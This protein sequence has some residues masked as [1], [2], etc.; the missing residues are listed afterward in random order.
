[1]R[2][3]AALAVGI[4][5]LCAAVSYA[6]TRRLDLMPLPRS[7]LGPGAAAL[8]LAPDSGI[9][10]NA[11]AADNAGHG[12]TGSDL[13]RQGRTTGYT[14]DYVLPHASV[15]QARHELLGVQTIAELY[16]NRATATRGLAF[17]RSVTRKRAGLQPNGVTVAVSAFRARVGDGSFA[18]EL[19]Y[20]AG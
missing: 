11:A 16:R 9:V 15:P 8:A 20:R 14:L 1:M 13:A 12:L 19:T 3:V 6:G 7:A 18:F 17:W 2:R 5:L 4:A 10:S